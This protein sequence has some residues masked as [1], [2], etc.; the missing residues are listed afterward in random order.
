VGD[1]PRD[2]SHVEVDDI[3]AEEAIPAS[4]MALQ[5]CIDA[6]LDGLPSTGPADSTTQ[7]HH[8]E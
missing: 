7:D 8:P 5:Q 1:L 3:D 4:L 6:Y 2:G